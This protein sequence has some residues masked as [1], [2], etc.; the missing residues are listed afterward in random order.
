MKLV[1]SAQALQNK[2]ST[3]AGAKKVCKHTS[4]STGEPASIFEETGAKR[5]SIY[6]LLEMYLTQLHF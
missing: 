1:F 3:I 6:S 4:R 5:L 2:P